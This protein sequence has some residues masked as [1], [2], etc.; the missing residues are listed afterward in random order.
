M[1]SSSVLKLKKD[2]KS[3]STK[4]RALS[5]TW[6]F[7]TGP[8]EYG[9]GDKFLGVTVPNIRKVVKKYNT[10][11]LVDIKEIL[12]SKIHEERLCAVLILVDQYKRASEKEKKSIFDFY[13]KNTKHINNWD[14]VDSSAPH[15]VGGYL[16]NKKDRKIL[17]KLA[18]S[19]NLWEKRIAIVSTLAFIVLNREYEWTFRITEMLMEDKHDLIHKACGWMLR[20]VGKRVSED[21]LRSFLDNYAPYMPRTM[22][23]YSI[24]KFSNAKRQIYLSMR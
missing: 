14:F 16:L 23:R 19:K 1:K 7:K 3:L 20:E 17:L 4:E 2:L 15:I 12:E 24:E 10:I 5:N 22:L 13:L 6:F 9:E 21:T 11:T 8:G 18:K